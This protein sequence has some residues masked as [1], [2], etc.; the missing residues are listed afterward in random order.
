MNRV[1]RSDGEKTGVVEAFAPVELKYPG[2]L[3]P[4]GEYLAYCREARIYRDGG[5]KR[6]T[7]LLDF[8]IVSEQF[9]T[10]A[11]LPLWF[12]LGG[13]QK[14]RVTRRSNYLAA[15]IHANGAAPSRFDRLSPKVFLR[16]MCRVTVADTT[17][18][19]PRSIVKTIVSWETAS[20]VNSST[21]AGAEG[22][23]Q[24]TTQPADAI[25]KSWVKEMASAK[26]FDLREIPQ[27]G[28]AK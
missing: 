13:G 12:N 27:S 17:G 3:I 2:T 21:L 10:I 6:W 15:W 22:S 19:L 4:G 25:F 11:Q 20:Q 23:S 7:C 9:E 26:A 14:A 24:Q 8:D 28:V 1:D 5:F 18:P 16:R